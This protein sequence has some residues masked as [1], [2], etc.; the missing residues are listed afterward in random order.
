MT[1]LS[2][3]VLEVIIKRGASID[4]RLSKLIISSL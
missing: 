4:E 3:Q 2:D 1:G